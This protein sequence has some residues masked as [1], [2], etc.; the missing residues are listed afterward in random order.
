MGNRSATGAVTF[1]SPSWWLLNTLTGGAAPA[2]FKGFAIS[3]PGG[4]RASTG[5]DHSPATV[6]EWMA[7]L[8]ASGVEKDGESIALTATRM[9]VVHV[10]AY[11]SRLI[12]IGTVVAP[13]G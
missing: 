11:D 9:V 7:V 3:A 4:W 13:I 2:S 8:V 1:W 5:F 12:G 10:D 6:P